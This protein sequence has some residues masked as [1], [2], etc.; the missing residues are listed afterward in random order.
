MS[1][2][3]MNMDITTHSCADGHAYGP[4][5]RDINRHVHI[6]SSLV[7]TPPQTHTHGNTLGGCRA[8]L[9]WLS[10]IKWPASSPNALLTTVIYSH[11][12]KGG[13]Q[14]SNTCYSK[15]VTPNQARFSGEKCF[16]GGVE[17]SKD[18]IRLGLQL[19]H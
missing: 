17:N 9:C 5:Q 18:N 13:E 11:G 6:Y 4:C 1:S 14:S 2:S 3:V 8:L 19:T 10:I 16:L 12:S 15:G 7:F